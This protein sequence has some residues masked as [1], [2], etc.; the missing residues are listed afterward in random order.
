MKHNLSRM[1]TLFTFNFTYGLLCFCFFIKVQFM[2]GIYL[3]KKLK[4]CKR[5][6][7][8]KIKQHLKAAS[9]CI[10]TEIAI[11]MNGGSTGAIRFATDHSSGDKVVSR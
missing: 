9:K 8:H 4:K 1:F 5:F 2:K 7:H 11:Q 6:Y 10:N 3:N